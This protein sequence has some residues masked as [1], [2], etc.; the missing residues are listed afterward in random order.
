MTKLVK[1]LLMLMLKAWWGDKYDFA[2]SSI[3]IKYWSC[4]GNTEQK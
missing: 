1:L 2:A 3:N 4:D